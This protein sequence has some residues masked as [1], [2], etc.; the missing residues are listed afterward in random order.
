MVKKYNCPAC[1][2]KAQIKK[3]NERG[4][5]YYHYNYKL[6]SIPISI[7]TI[8]IIKIEPECKEKIDEKYCIDCNKMM[9]FLVLEEGKTVCKNPARP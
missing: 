2:K 5:T 1:R 6:G 7:C 4:I 9:E 8:P 3:E